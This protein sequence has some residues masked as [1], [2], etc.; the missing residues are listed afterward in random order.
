MWDTAGELRMNSSSSEFL[1][2]VEQ[3][4]DDQLETIYN[5][6]VPTQEIALKTSR[7]Q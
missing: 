5:I 2:M 4:Q 7:E 1:R 3:R 6:S